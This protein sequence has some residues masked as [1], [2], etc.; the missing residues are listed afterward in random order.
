MKIPLD[1]YSLK[2]RLFPAF[3]MLSPI[4]LGAIAWAPDGNLPL[5]SMLGLLGSGGLSVLLA[6]FVRDIGKEKE[7]VLWRSWGGAPTTQL[8]RHRNTSINPHIRQKWRS[9][10]EQIT[11]TTLPT[12]AEEA[13]DPNG[14]D[15]IYEAAVLHLREIKREGA[16]LALKENTSY[17][18]RRN[19]W[20][21][22]SA[23]ITICVIGLLSCAVA[24]GFRAMKGSQELTDQPPI[25]CATVIAF[26]LVMWVVRVTPTWVRTTAFEY[27]NRL[28]GSMLSSEAAKADKR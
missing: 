6:E 27:A 25:I 14:T 16:D 5:G 20:A 10:I 17:G 7:P 3:I 21:I 19:L 28:L 15:Q 11:D 18:F 9:Q 12:L 4:A 1:S 23:G 24:T 22:R 13:D 26:L 8:L 2:A